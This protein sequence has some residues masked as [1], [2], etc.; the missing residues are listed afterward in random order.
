MNNK[1]SL[2]R[3]IQYGTIQGFYWMVF[4]SGIGYV[5]TYL[6]NW[7][8]NNSEI[9]IILAIANILAIIIQPIIAT[10]I[11]R[12]NKI[13]IIN[14]ISILLIYILILSIV[15]KSFEVNN[16]ILYFIITSLVTVIVTLHPFIN[17]LSFLYDNKNISINFGI[18]R[19]MGSISYAILSIVI[20]KVVH[21]FSPMI[22]P[23]FYIISII[24]LLIFII[25]YGK[26]Y[27]DKLK[28]DK[29]SS[30]NNK[31]TIKDMGIEDKTIIRF[32]KRYKRFSLL[33][34]GAT[35]VLFDHSMINNFF[36]QIVYNIGGTDTEM[37]R[38]LSL[39]AGL[40]L[41]IMLLFFK[42]KN[43]INCGTL[44][45]ISAFSFVIKHIFTYFA[46]TMEML[47]VAQMLQILGFGLFIPATVFYV[48]QIMREDDAVKGQSMITM[49]ITLGGVFA[50][51]VGG[52][53]LD[54]HGVGV[55]LLVGAIAS[56]IGAT[57]MVIAADKVEHIK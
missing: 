27:N 32:I 42:L 52:K 9:G 23:V 35:F 15:L 22:I 8:L 6:L 43:K 19:G 25:I 40:E 38:A 50:S 31:S 34:V 11:D 47:Y 17:S 29:P 28:L 21:K 3:N 41:P 4:C 49:A 20:G 53:L 10:C 5:S 56:I 1:V 39:G 33:L 54:L 55:M 26:S 18:C 46:G 51:I 14:I 24:G 7:G 48:Q 16:L 13:S 30:S 37:G 44:L 45:K 57:I 36:T 12:N 2:I